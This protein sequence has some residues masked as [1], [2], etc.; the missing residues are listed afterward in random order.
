MSGEANEPN[1]PE[2]ETIGPTP[3]G[4]L[5]AVGL[6][7]H[8]DAIESGRVYGW[9]W[10]PEAPNEHVSIDIYHK[11]AFVDRTVANRFRQ[12][13]ADLQMADGTHAFV[14]DLPSS[15]RDTDSM[16]IA[17]YF[18]ETQAPLSR[19]GRRDLH[20][21]TPARDSVE[22]L[23]GRIDRMEASLQQVYRALHFFRSR[24]EALS[25]VTR[26]SDL[27]T[28]EQ[29]I[30]IEKEQRESR[31]AQLFT[32]AD[33]INSMQC[34]IERVDHELHHYASIRDVD[35]IAQRLRRRLSFHDF[36]HII[37]LCLSFSALLLFSVFL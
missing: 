14:F 27:E 35:D 4:R 3:S 9:A 23:A 1:V 12:D 37:S 6:Q 20:L 10:N 28:L 32:L 2:C 26:C 24:D 5:G 7:G 31:D 19:D 33:Q 22:L 21:P 17:V 11:G 8:V 15:A 18:T 30:A 36:A 25:K 34:L 13:L 16:A 29:S